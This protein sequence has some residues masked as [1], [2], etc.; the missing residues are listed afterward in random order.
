MAARAIVDPSS[1]WASL[2]P[3]SRSRS[4]SRSSSRAWKPKPTGVHP[5]HESRLQIQTGSRAGPRSTT[6]LVS[7]GSRNTT[8]TTHYSGGTVLRRYNITASTTTTT[9]GGDA[10]LPDYTASLSQQLASSPPL[11]SLSIPSSTPPPVPIDWCTHPSAPSDHHHHP[12][13]HGCDRP[14]TPITSVS[15][16]ISNPVSHP[17]T[18]PVTEPIFPSDPL[19]IFPTN[20][21]FSESGLRAKRLALLRRS[22]NFSREWRHDPKRNKKAQEAARRIIEGCHPREKKG[23]MRD[24][25]KRWGRE[26]GTLKGLRGSKDGGAAAAAAAG[27]RGEEGERKKEARWSWKRGWKGDNGLGESGGHKSKEKPAAAAA[28]AAEQTRWQLAL[29]PGDETT[30]IPAPSPVPKPPRNSVV[31]EQ[32]Y[33]AEGI[34]VG[35][36]KTSSGSRRNRLG[37]A[38]EKDTANRKY[39]NNAGQGREVHEHEK[40]QSKQKNRTSGLWKRGMEKVKKLLVL[41]T[42]KSKARSASRTATST[43]PYNAAKAKIVDTSLLHPHWKGR[44]LGEV[45]G[46]NDQHP[47]SESPAGAFLLPS[48]LP[49]P[50]HSFSKSATM[51]VPETTTTMAR[52]N[53][54]DKSDNESMVAPPTTWYIDDD[55]VSHFEEG[56][57][58]RSAEEKGKGID[59]SLYH[60]DSVF[61]IQTRGF[62]P[63]RPYPGPKERCKCYN[64]TKTL[65]LR[66]TAP[67]ANQENGS[68]MQTYQGRV[69]S[70]QTTTSTRSSWSI[71]SNQT[72]PEDQFPPRPALRPSPTYLGSLLPPYQDTWALPPLQI[73]GDFSKAPE[74]TAF[75]HT[76]TGRLSGTFQ[77]SVAPRNV[78]PSR[79]GSHGEE[80]DEN[81]WS[82]TRSKNRHGD[83]VKPGF[84]GFMKGGETYYPAVKELTKNLKTKS[85][86]TTTSEQIPTKAWTETWTKTPTKTPQKLA[87]PQRTN[88]S[89]RLL[90]HQNHPYSHRQ[91]LKSEED[92]PISSSSRHVSAEVTSNTTFDANQGYYQG[93][94]TQEHEYEHERYDEVNNYL[95]GRAPSYVGPGQRTPDM[96]FART[97]PLAL[98]SSSSSSSLFS[99][100]SAPVSPALLSHVSEEGDSNTEEE[101]PEIHDN[102]GHQSNDKHGRSHRNYYRQSSRNNKSNSNGNHRS[103]KTS[104]SLSIS[105]VSTRARSPR[106]FR[107]SKRENKKNSNGSNAHAGPSSWHHETKISSTNR[108]RSLTTSTTTTT[109][110]SRVSS[111]DEIT[112]NDN[113][114]SA[115]RTYSHSQTRSD[116]TTTGTT[117]TTGTMDSGNDSRG[118]LEEEETGDSENGLLRHARTASFQV[119]TDLLIIPLEGVEEYVVPPPSSSSSSHSS[120]DSRGRGIDGEFESTSKH[121]IDGCLEVPS[122][123]APETNM[124]G[125]GERRGCAEG[126]RKRDEGGGDNVEGSWEWERGRKRERERGREGTGYNDVRGEYEYGRG[127][128]RIVDGGNG[129]V[130]ERGGGGG[131][132]GISIEVRELKDEETETETDTEKGGSVTPS[133]GQ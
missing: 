110:S 49:R 9:N 101:D 70:Y 6:S 119:E 5:N 37:Q 57:R 22:S 116:Q 61:K 23:G 63:P 38:E 111:L 34:G 122:D 90:K 67:A 95:Y 92:R 1:S 76:P 43:R 41:S 72:P 2:L 113:S 8:T 27:R 131:G 18:D 100:A 94:N 17:L 102:L 86:K 35:S 75:T 79:Y 7:S 36:T 77:K 21:T 71:S 51:E 88:Q 69:P 52:D 91:I 55:E 15:F 107:N 26:L 65:L 59:Y 80:E 74:F 104:W 130:N 50:K 132:G 85:S 115:P 42:D 24:R 33:M 46:I 114:S 39:A 118:T 12:C 28:A 47:S 99:S 4:R 117:G 123:D 87:G 96:F 105:I 128:W 10:I 32:L 106:G 60:E 19:D 121:G 53:K 108:K 20:S 129:R 14:E 98:T 93:I 125:D 103:Y 126:N 56:K 66:E 64:C 13:P 45:K 54:T 48:L 68:L 124:N 29:G 133:T 44:H 120:S 97:P 84:H 30:S 31:M 78:T 11:L 89:Q 83:S 16:P 40:M 127:G 73:S 82:G 3:P 112:T 81:F 58:P 25:V 109:G 62:P